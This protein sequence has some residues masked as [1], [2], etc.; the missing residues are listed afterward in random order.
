MEPMIDGDAPLEEVVNAL[1][2]ADELPRSEVSEDDDEEHEH[3][4][5]AILA[6][7]DPPMSM[8][9]MIDSD[10]PLEEVVNALNSADELPR[11]EVSEDDDEEHEYART[12]ILAP[13]DPLNPADPTIDG[14][15]RG[16]EAVTT[17]KS[18][19]ESPDPKATGNDDADE[20]H[21]Y[22][23]TVILPP[24]DT[25]PMKSAAPDSAA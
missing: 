17:L 9:P 11:S 13:V 23:R 25:L 22:S 16:E 14:D 10:V 12:S 3:S 20:E 2:S 8:E 5:T 7:L 6:P 15:A 1:N 21:E 24:A 18:V 19:P 4:R